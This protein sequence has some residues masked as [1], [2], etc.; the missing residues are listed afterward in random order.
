GGTGAS[1]APGV[2]GPGVLTTRGTLTFNS[3]ATYVCELTTTNRRFDQ[4]AAKG[5]TVNAGALFS[6][7]SIGN[8]AMPSGTV[9]TVIT[10]TAATPM[11]GTF[12]NLAENSTFT[13][14]RKNYLV[15][16]E[17]GSGNDLTVAVAP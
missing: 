8:R 1:L 9:F 7:V 5:V 13:A 15:S 10:N 12:S 6:F 11:V 4:V 2:N 16:Y 3:D 14:G 17:G